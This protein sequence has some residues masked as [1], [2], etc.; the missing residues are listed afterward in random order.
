MMTGGV[1]GG[2]GEGMST[3][4]ET[5]AGDVLVTSMY[6]STV[7]RTARPPAQQHLSNKGRNKGDA[8][9][10]TKSGLTIAQIA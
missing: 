6:E 10:D 9:V 4:D 3:C 8:S 5:G 1:A 2:P 7:G